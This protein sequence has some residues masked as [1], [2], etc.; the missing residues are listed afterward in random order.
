MTILSEIHTIEYF[1][2][3]SFYNKPIEK[4]KN[5]CLKNTDLLVGLPLYEKLDVIK[6]DQAFSGYAISYKVEI[7]AKKD[8]IIQLKASKLSI[9]DLFSNLLNETTGFKYRLL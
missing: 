5:K 8:P 6:T 9:R 4:P 7:I 3:L 1:K 2:E